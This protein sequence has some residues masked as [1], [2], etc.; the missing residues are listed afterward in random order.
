M[1]KVHIEEHEL[2]DLKKIEPS[3]RPEMLN[4]IVKEIQGLLDLQ[5]FSLEPLPRCYRP[6]DS[7]IVLKVKYRANG[8]FD[9]FKARLV[10]RG[11]LA[12]I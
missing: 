12:R 5:T 8:A 2:M 6:L 7:R 4:A 1:D 10:A 3:Q 11:F 9:K